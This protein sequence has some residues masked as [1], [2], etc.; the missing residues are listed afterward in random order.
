MP[1]VPSTKPST[2]SQATYPA[3]SPAFTIFFIHSIESDGEIKIAPTVK[4]PIRTRTGS[5]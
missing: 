1:A 3:V 2:V 5:V 4:A